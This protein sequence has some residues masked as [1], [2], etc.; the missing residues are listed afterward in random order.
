[1]ET[2]NFSLIDNTFLS[3]QDSLFEIFQSSELNF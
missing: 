1:M 2:V 3:I